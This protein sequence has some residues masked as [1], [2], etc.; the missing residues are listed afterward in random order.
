[1]NETSCEFGFAL[2][3]ATLGSLGAAVYRGLMANAVPSEVPQAAADI[4]RDTLAGATVAAASLADPVGLLLLM[5]ARE[6]FTSGM[7][8]AALVSAVILLGIAV[9]AVTMLRHV[10]PL[11]EVSLSRLWPRASASR[12][13]CKPL[14]PDFPRVGR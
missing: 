11:A 9:L 13:L 2:G 4:A 8:A 10:R 5:T 14:P 3:I 12:R 1:V 7:H 6:A